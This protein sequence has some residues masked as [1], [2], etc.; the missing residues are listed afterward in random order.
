MN[1]LQ[2]GFNPSLIESIQ[3]RNS[4]SPS[5]NKR[6]K[7]AIS[8]FKR[9][10]FGY[11]SDLSAYVG[12]AKDESAYLSGIDRQFIDFLAS[13]PASQEYPLSDLYA[14]YENHEDIK[15]EVDIILRLTE[16]KFALN[17]FEEVDMVLAS[18]ITE[19]MSPLA[20]EGLLRAT[21]RFK[22]VLPSWNEFLKRAEDTLR[23]SNI[24]VD[25]VLSGMR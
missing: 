25:I 16:K 20:I 7:S 8:S 2:F 4:S 19:Y 13:R 24:D 12:F 22:H 10:I 14:L 11:L 15:N 5:G 23:D 18:A 21:Y 3:A 17:Q 6:V 9:Q 1:A